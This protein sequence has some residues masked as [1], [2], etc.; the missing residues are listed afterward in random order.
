MLYVTREMAK[1][2]YRAEGPIKLFDIYQDLEADPIQIV[3]AAK[4]FQRIGVAEFDG[5]TLHP[6]GDQRRILF[7]NRDKFFGPHENRTSLKMKIRAFE[8]YLPDL[9]LIDLEFFRNPLANTD[10]SN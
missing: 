10:G 6:S 9:S 1:A 5:R 7:A 4:F 8:P 2:L 3:V